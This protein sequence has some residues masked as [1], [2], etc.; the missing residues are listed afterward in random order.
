MRVVLVDGSHFIYRAYWATQ[1]LVREDG[2]PVNAVNAYCG[3]LTRVIREH[4]GTHFAVI[5]DAGK[6]NWRHDIYPEYKSHRPPA[7]DQLRPQFALIREATRAYN[8]PCIELVGFEADDLIASYTLQAQM[9]GWEVVINS[10]DKDLMQLIRPGVTMFD[11]MTLQTIGS[12][13]VFNK[14]GVQPALMVDFQAL[15][16]DAVDNVPGVH[17]IGSVYAAKLLAL[18]HNLRGVLAAAHGMKEGKQ[19]DALLRHHDNALLSQQ[20]VQLRTDAPLPEPLTSLA[21]REP[22]MTVLAPWL[23]TQG[24]LS[25]LAMLGMAET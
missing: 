22:D 6:H 14:F 1:P 20:L 7:P 10:S 5:F 11:P 23:R 4:S 15:V 2:T 21:I 9:L 17:G 16:G 18:H 19:R 12:T 13:E 25:H 24:F 8:V 3:M